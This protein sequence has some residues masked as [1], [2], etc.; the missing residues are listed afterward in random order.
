[1]L[2]LVLIALVCALTLPA[3]ADAARRELPRGWL[4][5]V[6]DGP[7][8]D[9]AFAQAPAEWDRLASSGYY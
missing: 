5:V 9:P 8:T 6:V 2:R 7:M 3:T 1:M 4:G